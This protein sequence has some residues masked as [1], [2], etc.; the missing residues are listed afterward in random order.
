MLSDKLHI[1]GVGPWRTF[2]MACASGLNALVGDRGPSKSILLDVVWRLCTNHWPNEPT[3]AKRAAAQIYDSIT[4]STIRQ[5][6]TI[7][8]VAGEQRW[9]RRAKQETGAEHI[10]IY[11]RALNALP[12]LA[13][14]V[15]YLREDAAH[16]VQ[17]G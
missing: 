1:S 14:I 2:E 9:D 6:K 4:F 15:A 12:K 13:T 11:A 7:H 10:E 8:D 17:R 5:H 16:E 3:L